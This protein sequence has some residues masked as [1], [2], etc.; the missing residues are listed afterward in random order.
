[1]APASR[2]SLREAAAL[3]VPPSQELVDALRLLP[4]PLISR[5]P[6]VADGRHTRYWISTAFA[7]WKTDQPTRVAR[8]TSR[9]SSTIW[10]HSDHR[11]AIEEALRF[12]KGNARVSS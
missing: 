1:L 11:F 10:G 9:C 7:A 4:I 3:R 6:S 8:T 5:R 12:H 2:Y